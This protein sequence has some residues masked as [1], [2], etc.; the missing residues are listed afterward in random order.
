MDVWLVLPCALGTVLAATAQV[1]GDEVPHP[2]G[3][4]LTRASPSPQVGSV[5][6]YFP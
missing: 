2:V 5:L 1:R 6:V 4:V 3:P